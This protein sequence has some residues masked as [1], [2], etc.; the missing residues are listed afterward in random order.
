MRQVNNNL[1]RHNKLIY[2]T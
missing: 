1:I 2:K